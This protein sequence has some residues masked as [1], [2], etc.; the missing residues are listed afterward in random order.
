MNHVKN[1]N[2]STTYVYNTGKYDIEEDV[3]ELEFGVFIDGT[4]NN[5]DNKSVS[6]KFEL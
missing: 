3:I 5:Q 6:I 4:L 2:M 1:G